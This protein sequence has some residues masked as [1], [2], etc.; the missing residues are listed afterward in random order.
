VRYESVLKAFLCCLL[1]GGVAVGYVR[2]TH[3]NSLLT[4]RISELQ[5]EI[6]AARDHNRKQREQ[7]GELKSPRRLE[8]MARHLDLD[9]R[10]SVPGQTVEVEFRPFQE[11][12]VARAERVVPVMGGEK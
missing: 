3:E 5:M 7:L 12:I 11:S 2:Q 4:G 9:L 8:E 10:P 1:I 6:E